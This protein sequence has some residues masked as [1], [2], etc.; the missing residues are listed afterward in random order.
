MLWSGEKLKNLYSQE[1]EL[2]MLCSFDVPSVKPCKAFPI[3]KHTIYFML[4]IH[5][6]LQ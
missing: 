6:V 1:F 5:T 4:H 2:N 3:L